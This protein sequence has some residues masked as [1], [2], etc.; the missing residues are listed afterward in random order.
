[1]R[2][3]ARGGAR[4]IINDLDAGVG[5]FHD[6]Q[7][8]VNNQMVSGTLMNLCDDPNQVRRGGGN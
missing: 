2:E 1:M 3:R 6:T 8:T 4:Q 5:R 7:T